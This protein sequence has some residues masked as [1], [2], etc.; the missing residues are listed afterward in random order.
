M[1][2]STAG[3]DEIQIRYGW[4]YALLL[5]EGA[6][7]EA[8]VATPMMCSTQDGKMVLLEELARMGSDLQDTLI[9]ILSE[10]IM[11]V[12]ELNTSIDA[13]HGFNVIA[14]ANNRDKGVN[15]LSSALKRASMSRPAPTRDARR[16]GAN[17]LQAGRRNRP[18]PGLASSRPGRSGDRAL[19]RP[20]GVD[21]NVRRLLLIFRGSAR[22]YPVGRDTAGRFRYGV[23]DLT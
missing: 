20:V 5:A 17:R 6:S 23:L 16:R 11:P 19:R 8:L 14:A 15:D 7:R 1:I 4:N 22:L 21:G 10:K 2:Q 18:Q 13:V 9:T 3:T 12:P